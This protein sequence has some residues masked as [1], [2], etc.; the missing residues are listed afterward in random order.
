MNLIPFAYLASTQELVDVADV[1]SGK[2]CQCVC[3]SCKIPLIAK[4]G[5]VKEWH[6]A[7]DSQFIDKEQTEPCDFSWAVA[8]KMMIKQLLMDG[9][10]ISLP[11]YHME[12]PS[13][14]YKSTNQK[15]LITKPSRVK[16]SNPTLK[17]YGCDIILEVG[18]KK[19]GLIFFMSKKNT[20]DEQTI[21]PHL[22]GLIG[23]DINGFAYDE[24]G[25]AINHLR[26]YLKLS[27][28]SHVRS[29]SWLYHARQRSVIEKE[30]QRQRT[31]KN[32]ELS[33]DARLGRNKALDTTV[34]KFQ[35]S[36]FC[37]ACK[38]SYQGENIGLNPCP[39][40]NS[41]FYRKAV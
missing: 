23:V 16:Y 7:H 40:C 39:K 32:L 3:P 5:M 29:K 36:W 6:F 27:I 25:K 24:T 21:D 31:L 9:T 30:L 15:V 12:L 19:L 33:R 20:M 1:P 37:V 13:I 26:A 28:E 4:K 18:G 2:D 41:H 10:E 38:H 14:G 11:D 35:S 17:E 34:D 8:V 22:V